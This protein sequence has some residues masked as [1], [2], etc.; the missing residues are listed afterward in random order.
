[1]NSSVICA[2]SHWFK[3]KFS[4]LPERIGP[5]GPIYL[6]AYNQLKISLSP[7]FFKGDFLEKFFKLMTLSM[8]VLKSKSFHR[9]FVHNMGVTDEFTGA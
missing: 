8:C 7:H 9:P 1:M 5:V 6:L 3:S 2:Q 4:P